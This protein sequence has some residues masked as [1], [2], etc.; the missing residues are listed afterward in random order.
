[1]ANKR[2]SSPKSVSHQLKKLKSKTRTIDKE[3]KKQQS[4]YKKQFRKKV[5]ALKKSGLISKKVDARR[6]NPTKALTNAIKTFGDVIDKTA[7]VFKVSAD[8]AKQYAKMGYRVKRGRV[9][10]PKDDGGYVPTRGRDKGLIKETKQVGEGPRITRTV[11]PSTA[12]NLHDFLAEL[13]DNPKYQNLKD[14]ES[15]G[16]RFFGW[17]LSESFTDLEDLLEFFERYQA[18]ETA[19]SRAKDKTEV[20]NNI[21]IVKIGSK[22]QIS[23]AKQIN[24]QR[25]TVKAAKDLERKQRKPR[26]LNEHQLA[27]KRE[28]AREY[29]RRTYDTF[30]NTMKRRKQRGTKKPRK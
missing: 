2:K 10:L 30:E 21:E 3:F 25:A 28:R 5:S 9:A 7:R 20:I 11:F 27:K 29:A 14:G 24:K 15:F 6:A 1:M 17:N 19:I 12:S 22:Q 16:I 23:W 8:K 4:D 18:I 13:E 26:K